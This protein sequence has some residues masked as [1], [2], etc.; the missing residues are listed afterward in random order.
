METPFLTPV[1]MKQEDIDRWQ[2]ERLRDTWRVFRIMSEFVE[3]FETLGRIGPCVSVFGSARTPP[4][5]PY[6]T[7]GVD[8][9]KALVARGYGVITGGGPGIME[10]ANR[11][12]R[13][14]G[15]VSVG[16][17]ITLPREQYSNPFIDPDKL[18]DFNFFFARKTMFV[19]YAMGFVVLPGGYGTL[20]ELFEA[21]TLI[22]TH[23]TVKFPVVLMGTSFWSGMLDWLTASVLEE[24]NI[25]AEDQ[26]L[27]VITDDPDEAADTIHEFCRVH[28]HMVTLEA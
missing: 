27:F 28:G 2:D 18:I 26:D 17:N 22:Q 6:Y 15:G 10:A 9:G 25:S 4:D 16:L 5:T 14:A 3:G 20:D 11:G 12:A 23:K 1:K 8:V 24:G 13:E 21:L 19:K 7:M